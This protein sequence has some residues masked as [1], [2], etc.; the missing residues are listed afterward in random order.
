MSVTTIR[1]EELTIVVDTTG[2]ENLAAEVHDRAHDLLDKV[3][4]D[5]EAT[6]R[7]LAPVDTGALKASI[8]TSG[9]TGRDNYSSGKSAAQAAGR[10][11]NKSI[12]FKPEVRSGD[13]YT[14][15]IAASVNYAIFP[16]LRGQAYM[17]PAVE[18]HRPDFL[19]AWEQ[20]VAV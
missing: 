3:A 15:I 9:A 5:I 20:L 17:V 11:G 7:S 1:R 6:A 4:F 16:E 13:K 12:E 8:Y 2:L 10:K 14:R 19:R 18:L